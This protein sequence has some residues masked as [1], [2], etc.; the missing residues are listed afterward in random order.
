MMPGLSICGLSDGAAFA[1]RTVMKKFR[2]ELEELVRSDDD[3]AIRIALQV[4]N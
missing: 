1:I 4:V 2:N 3:E